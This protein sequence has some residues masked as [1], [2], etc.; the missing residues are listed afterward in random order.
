MKN[1]IDDRCLRLAHL[2]ITV[3]YCV[4][5]YH[6]GHMLWVLYLALHFLAL[7]SWNSFI[8]FINV[9][10]CLFIFTIFK[11]RTNI[12]SPQWN[13]IGVF[14]SYTICLIYWKAEKHFLH[15]FLLVPEMVQQYI[16]F[17]CALIPLPTITFLL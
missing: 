2:F 9:I 17:L 12:T 15:S 14:L 8:F 3:Q 13:G 1:K 10:F 7:W 6:S 4:K 5:S 16:L 11:C